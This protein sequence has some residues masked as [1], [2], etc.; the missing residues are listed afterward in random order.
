MR[1]HHILGAFP[2]EA[3]DTSASCL[4]RDEEA[5]ESGQ[6]LRRMARWQGLAMGRIAWKA[7]M[8]FP[9][10][11]V[12][13]RWHLEK[14][15]YPM[16]WHCLNT[17]VWKRPS[18]RSKVARKK[19]ESEGLGSRS[20]SQNKT[21]Q[22]QTKKPPQELGNRCAV[23]G[24]SWL[25]SW[26]LREGSEERTQVVWIWCWQQG[27]GGYNLLATDWTG[28]K[29]GWEL[30]E[31]TDMEAMQSG[32]QQSEL[33]AESH[34]R[35]QGA[36]PRRPSEQRL[37]QELREWNEFPKTSTTFYQIVGYAPSL[38]QISL[39]ISAEFCIDSRTSRVP[40]HNYVWWVDDYSWFLA[41]WSGEPRYSETKIQEW[42]RYYS[43]GL[44]QWV[45]SC[46]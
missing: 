10:N 31:H 15:S 2:S 6:T 43:T 16:T 42:H 25:L 3:P 36:A 46:W 24:W 32:R 37:E 20:L 40:A 4:S 45:Q 39:P 17:D 18:S 27:L 11:S 21:K 14:C 8:K 13:L 7:I 44:P 9:D 34:R 5:A 23:W 12:K 28:A 30:R 38:F 19:L 22:K 1:S 26:C 35:D 41:R 29:Q 33:S